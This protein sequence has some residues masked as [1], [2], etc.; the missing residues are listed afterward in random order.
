MS[1]NIETL[2]WHGDRFGTLKMIDQTLLPS[3][4]NVIEC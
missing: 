1:S 2:S 3:E 4:L